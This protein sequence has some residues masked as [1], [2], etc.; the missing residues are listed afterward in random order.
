M[1]N[2]SS[3]LL[4]QFIKTMPAEWHDH[5]TTLFRQAYADGYHDGQQDL[6]DQLDEDDDDDLH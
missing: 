2:K 1:A 6:T 4:A 3:I 5:L